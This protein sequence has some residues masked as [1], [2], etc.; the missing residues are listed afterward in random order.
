MLSGTSGQFG[1]FAICLVVGGCFGI[2]WTGLQYVIKLL[3]NNLIVK[4]VMEFMFSGL[5][6]FCVFL[7]TVNLNFGVLRWYIIL[8][9]LV[10]FA[11]IKQFFAIM[12]AFYKKKEYNSAR[13]KE[14]GKTRI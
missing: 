5:L 14:R 3:K 12:L 10:G 4:F 8:G 9:I 1:I 13:M 2:I 11:L 6:F 7:I